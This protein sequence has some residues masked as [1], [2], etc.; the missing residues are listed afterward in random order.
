MPVL[1]SV[2]AMCMHL[3]ARLE[4]TQILTPFTESMKDTQRF[5][6]KRNKDSNCEWV[7]AQKFPI[8]D[9]KG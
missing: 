6:S 3:K 5:I 1:H 7:E 8:L 9:E 2:Q 4:Q